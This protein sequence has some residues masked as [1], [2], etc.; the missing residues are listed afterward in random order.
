[1]KPSEPGLTALVAALRDV[2]RDLI[3][4]TTGAGIS[5]ASGIP[6]F[7]GTDPDA[8]WK[9][10]VTELATARFFFEDPVESWRWYLQRFGNLLEKRPNPAHRAL[11]ALERWQAARGGDL[12]VVS[13]NVDTLHEQA[14]SRNLVKVHGRADRVRCSR[15]GCP[16]GAPKGSLP[17]AGCGE[18]AF[19]RDP[20]KATLPR[21]PACGSVLRQHVLLFDECYDEHEDYQWERVIAGATRAAVQL[22]VG[23]SFSVGVTDLVLNAALLQGRPTFLIDPG[24]QSPAPGV[25]VIRD[26]AEEAL[27]AVCAALGVAVDAASV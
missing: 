22:F 27:P 21:C 5:L 2:P 20:G 1:M 12:L 3:L 9:R 25:T 11:V 10:D 13:Q 15:V 19:R 14:G 4:V 24:L 23:T 26:P 17:R 6:T 8:V 7:R 16:N 18:E